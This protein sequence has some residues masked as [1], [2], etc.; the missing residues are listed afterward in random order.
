MNKILIALVINLIKIYK[1]FISPLI[2]ANCRFQPTCSSYC[3]E[4][5]NRHGFFKGLKFSFKRVLKCHPCGGSGYDPVPE[6]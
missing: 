4:A 5:L 2:G 6:E 3:E 1:K